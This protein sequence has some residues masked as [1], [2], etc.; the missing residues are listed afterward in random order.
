MNEDTRKAAPRLENTALETAMAGHAFL[1][2]LPPSV[3]RK[4]AD[5][6][7]LIRFKAG[8]RI[9]EE[10]DPANRFYL[11]VRG[12][13]VLGSPAQ[14]GRTV[15]LQKIGDGD[16]LGWSWLFPPYS[17]HFDAWAETDVEA[18]FFYG[19]RLREECDTDHDLGYELMKRMSS[20]VV[21]RLQVAR[22]KLVALSSA[23][24]R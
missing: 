2:D 20:I 8:D 23:K 17:W 18:I 10:G 14:E 12:T 7:M 4:L 16:V 21:Q 6:A 5:S 11:I 13:V 1:A 24:E 19:T 9:F 3:F 22:R 15:T